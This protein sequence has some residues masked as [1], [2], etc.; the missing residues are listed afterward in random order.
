MIT[1]TEA[2]VLRVI[3]YQSSSL[4]V[5]LFTRK[6]GKIAVI[7]RGAKRPKSKTASYLVPG[8]LLEVVYFMKTT[9]SVQTLSDVSFF[10]KLD[11]LR[12]D[13]EKMAL[14]VT[15]LELTSQLLHDNEPNDEMFSFLENFLPWL[16]EKAEVS[17]IIFPYVQI[18]LMQLLGVGL[19]YIGDDGT[20]DGTG[21]INIE[22]GTLTHQA[23]G[24]ESVKLTSTQFAFLR[25]SLH[26]MKSSLFQTNFEKNE[27]S[28][29]IEYLDRYFRFHFEGVKPRKSDAIFDQIL[30]R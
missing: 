9:R 22:S 23:E 12:F 16:N 15:V 8:H 11:A 17:R 14:S 27:L 24:S 19:Q 1:K 5:T 7:A 3:E 13:M 28:T 21:Y 30:S 4:I 6:H 26:H 29:L 2:V 20:N 10:R 25:E 18:R